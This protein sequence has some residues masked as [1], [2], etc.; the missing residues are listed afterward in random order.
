MTLLPSAEVAATA[1]APAPA[2]A[3][4]AP[5]EAD[6]ERDSLGF[7]VQLGPEQ[8]V[9]GPTDQGDNPFFSERR[10]GKLFAYFGTSRTI[11]WRSNNNARISRPR[12]IINRGSAGKFD[13]CGA[14]MQ[15]SIQK[16]TARHW[17][18][19]YHSEGKG[20]GQDKCDHY[21][22]TTVWRMAMVETTNGGKTWKRPNYPNNVVVTGVDATIS[23][24]VTNAGT[25]RV[26]KVGN[27]YYMFFKTAHGPQP[28]PSG[29]Q[30]ARARVGA[31]ENGLP[32]KFFKYYCH[33]A[34]P[35]KDAYCAFDEKGIGGKSTQIGGISEKAR[36]IAWN[37]ALDRW[38]GF[39][40]SGKRGFRMF[41]S[42]VG[43]GATPEARQHDALFDGDGNPKKWKNWT[44]TYPLVSTATDQYVDQ[45]G[46]H[47]RN[48]K[49]KQLYAYPSIGGMKG[50][51]WSTG[52]K[53]YV[54]YVKL[55]P[56]QKFTH[57]YLFRRQVKVVP[58]GTAFNRVE[59]TTYKNRKG[60]RLSSTE[61]PQSRSFRRVGP[62]GY[63]LAHGKAGWKQ[64]FD[65]TRRGDHALYVAKCRGGW[66][67]VR[68]VGFVRPRKGFG[69]NV[70]VFRCYDRQK[71]S[72]FASNKR[73]CDGAKREVRIGFALRRL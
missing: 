1:P 52:S 62:T 13:E 27:F 35:V 56:G 17:I 42:E 54:Y 46:G 10:G 51:S 39:D 68:R 5:A 4:V 26:V 33:P 7:A 72:H 66:K 21:G 32:G 37:S 57:R 65:C 43:T 64:V 70:P 11:E 71:R 8:R 6:A 50:S 40:A 49:S 38:I 24:G 30:V 53:F 63:L 34:T 20:P 44:D 69:A 55:F 2:P 67:P 14:W 41:A 28:G 19:F 47:I 73:R 3:A 9:T 18:A 25:G 58:S 16:L 60:K 15:G 45:W 31:G 61:A 29:I 12:I 22:D 59:L 48:H 36:Y 23:T